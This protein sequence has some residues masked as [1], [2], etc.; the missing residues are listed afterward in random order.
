MMKKNNIEV[1]A[2]SN[3][4]NIAVTQ[5]KVLWSKISTYLIG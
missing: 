3:K 4:L 5:I 2:T 1:C